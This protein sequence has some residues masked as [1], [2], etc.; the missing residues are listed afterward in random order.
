MLRR[1]LLLSALVTATL[2]SAGGCRSCS[3]CHDYDPPVLGCD[4]GGY[5]QRAGS[6][7]GCDGCGG[8]S[9]GACGCGEMHGGY[10]DYS[11]PHEGQPSDGPAI[12]SQPSDEE[13]GA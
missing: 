12:P 10:E 1:C 4:C 7:C 9:C 2:L 5:G 13:A 6:V 3:D 11:V 8:N